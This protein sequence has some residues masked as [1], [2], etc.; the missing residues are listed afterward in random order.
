MSRDDAGGAV[1][2]SAACLLRTRSIVCFM[3]TRDMLRVA[4]SKYRYGRSCAHGVRDLIVPSM[5]TQR[6][7]ADLFQR[8]TGLKL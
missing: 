2:A 4:L 7:V 6:Q 1:V 5:R 3:A 8:R